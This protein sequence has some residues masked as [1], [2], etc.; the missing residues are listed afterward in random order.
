MAKDEKSLDLETLKVDPRLWMR[1]AVQEE[2]GGAL[3]RVFKGT[4]NP[5]AKNPEEAMGRLQTLASSGKLYVRENARSGHFRKVQQDGENLKLGDVHEQKMTALASDPVLGLL[6]WASR[7]YF[8]WLGL[9]SISNWFDKKLKNREALLEQDALYKEEYKSLTKTEKDQLKQTRKL[10]KEE[11]KEAKQQQ[12][13]K[14]KKEK[15]EKKQ[16]KKQ[17]KEA[18]K[19]AKQKQKQERKNRKELEKALKERSKALEKQ[20]LADKKVAEARR[21]M[22]DINAKG[23]MDAPLNEPPAIELEQI[24]I[25]PE[26]NANEVENDIELQDIVPKEEGAERD[27]NENENVPRENEEQNQQEQHQLPPNELGDGPKLEA[28]KVSIHQEHEDRKQQTLQEKLTEEKQELDSVKQWRETL[29]TSLFSHEEGA[30]LKA[31]Y[32]TLKGDSNATMEY[33]TGAFIGI[34][35]LNEPGSQKNQQLLQ[36]MLH[37]KSLGN[38]ND[39]LIRQGMD[40]YNRAKDLMQQG[41]P[42]EMA[43]MFAKAAKELGQQVSREPNLSTNHIMIGRMLSNVMTVADNSNLRLP[44]NTDDFNIIRGARTMSQVAQKYYDARQTLGNGEM[45][46]QTEQGREALKDLLTGNAINTMIQTEVPDGNTISVTH[47]IMANGLWTETNLTQMTNQYAMK[48]DIAPGQV[49]KIL[50]QPDGMEAKKLGGRLG[51]SMVSAAVDVQKGRNLA[52]QKENIL[53]QDQP[54]VGLHQ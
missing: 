31:K 50:E 47:R 17:Q 36:D 43:N 52:N 30:D 11:K 41:N 16:A 35:S 40:A 33:L 39:A 10:E 13:A 51:T 42:G 20:Q 46:L 21:K 25:Q 14:D 2:E 45:N 24:N 8:K 23:E 54:V 28:N 6:M 15:Q 3:H 48:G 27:G 4:E 44:L 29:A 1:I 32:E 49:Q 9:E 37:S 5:F 34:L 38:E 7:G 12:K 26:A 22:L 19:L 53:Q 18:D